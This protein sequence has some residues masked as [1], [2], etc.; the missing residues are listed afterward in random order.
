M[1]KYLTK[2]VVTL[3]FVSLFADIGSEML[4]PVMPFYLKSIGFTALAIGVLEGFAQLVI[5]FTTGYFGSLS[6]KVG[7]RMPF[8]R[9][10]Y[11]LSAI[12]KTMMI[13]FVYPWWIFLSRLTDRL[14]KGIRT[15]SRDAIL[16][17]ES[18]DD[19]KGKVFGFH[20]AMDTFGAAVGP[21]IALVYLIYHP[22]D[23]RNLFLI[24]FAPGILSVAITFLVRDKKLA[25]P[26]SKKTSYNFF[27][28]L[29]YW[30]RSSPA[31][32]K[33]FIGLAGFA[34]FNSSDAF[35]FLAAKA[36][37]MQ[38]NS[39]IGAYIFYN[40]VYAGLSFPAG[41]L[42]DKFG[43]K[44]TFSIGLVLFAVV[45]AGIGFA[46]SEMEL[47]IYFF[48]YGVY[49]AFT[50]GVSNAWISK[51]CSKEERGT[52]IGLYK[53][54]SSIC[55]LLAST[56]AGFLWMSFSPFIA[57]TS[58]AVGALLVIFYFSVAARKLS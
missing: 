5:G 40:I 47:F 49:A 30:T 37:G 22:G 17:E 32:K 13:M 52:A 55:L 18:H 29:S 8:V 53:S 43:M 19:H 39:I 10:G 4:Y 7:K 44:K 56:L 3:S 24:A 25:K 20:R 1:R 50:E 2:T 12:S 46:K 14:G 23:Y 31:Y 28:F 27:N 26:V 48:V 51:H 6:D 54:I 36:A 9:T 45:Y 41:S 21:V 33:V 38:D 16:S 57:L 58:S 11:L 34:L 15:G 42:A 35:L